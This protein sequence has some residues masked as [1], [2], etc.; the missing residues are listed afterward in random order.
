M[1]FKSTTNFLGGAKL[2]L[3]GANAPLRPPLN[4]TLIVY[5]VEDNTY[6]YTKR[7]VSTHH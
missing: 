7:F 5:T 4:E 2:W 3:G 6:T 1:T